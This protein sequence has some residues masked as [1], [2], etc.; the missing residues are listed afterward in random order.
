MVMVVIKVGNN[1]RSC[2]NSPIF[3][4]LCCRETNQSEMKA[5]EAL[6]PQSSTNTERCDNLSTTSKHKHTNKIKKYSQPTSFNPS[7]LPFLYYEK[8]R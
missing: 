8:R 6:S 1:N 5:K 7:C 2:P 4:G 3:K